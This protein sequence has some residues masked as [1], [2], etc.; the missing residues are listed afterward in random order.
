MKSQEVLKHAQTVEALINALYNEIPMKDRQRV[1][2]HLH[3]E[4]MISL[5]Y[6]KGLSKYDKDSF[7]FDDKYAI[8]KVYL[9]EE[10]YVHYAFKLD[11]DQI[12]VVEHMPCNYPSMNTILHHAFDDYWNSIKDVEWITGYDATERTQTFNAIKERYE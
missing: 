7:D 11:T 2:H 4:A 12:L 8:H 5:H 6:L 1:D 3:N 10:G 9:S